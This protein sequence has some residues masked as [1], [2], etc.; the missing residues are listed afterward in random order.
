MLNTDHFPYLIID[1]SNAHLFCSGGPQARA[2]GYQGWQRPD[3][4]HRFRGSRPVGQT[5]P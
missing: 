5:I 4:P 2:T 3:A 1:D